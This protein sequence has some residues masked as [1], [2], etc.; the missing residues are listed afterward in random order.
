MSEED[1]SIGVSLCMHVCKPVKHNH[2]KNSKNSTE[3]QQ[4]GLFEHIPNL[5]LIFASQEF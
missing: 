3:I 5:V 1:F 2:G 4:R